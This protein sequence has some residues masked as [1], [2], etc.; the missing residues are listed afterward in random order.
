V[1]DDNGKEKVVVVNPP[2]EL[3]RNKILQAKNNIGSVWF[4]KKSNG[5]LRKMTY[6]LH[7]INPSVAKKPNGLNVGDRIGS[8][9]KPIKRIDKKKDIDARNNNM[10]VF[11]C[12]A[13]VRDMMGNKIGRGA[14]K[15]IPLENVIRIKSNGKVYEIMRDEK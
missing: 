9:I 11:D 12:N 1:R 6:R 14:W 2:I 7:V 10:T 13:V 8:N 5:E 4:M 3:I 15:T